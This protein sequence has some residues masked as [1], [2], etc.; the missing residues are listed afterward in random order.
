[1]LALLWGGISTRPLHE[2]IRLKVSR[3]VESR[4]TPCAAMAESFQAKKSPVAVSGADSGADE[5][6][7]K[8]AEKLEITIKRFI[9]W[10][11]KIGRNEP[12]K[13]RCARRARH[14]NG[15]EQGPTRPI[16]RGGT[17]KN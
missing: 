2:T 1:M 5:Q 8:R 15:L 12:C 14:Q 11:A 16:G 7:P 6:A 4:A 9:N 3:R 13:R 17:H 10:G